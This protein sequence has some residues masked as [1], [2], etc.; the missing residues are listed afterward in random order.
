M[1]PDPTCARCTRRLPAGSSPRR[2]Y[3]GDRCRKAA[4]RARSGAAV[5]SVTLEGGRVTE[6]VADLLLQLGHCAGVD[7][8]RAEVA[9]AMARLVD[10]GSVP[11]ARELRGVLDDLDAIE[12]EDVQAFRALIRTPARMPGPA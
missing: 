7:G 11:A 5:P 2:L 12:G 4:A 1:N 6:A 3:C 8:A 10:A 9:L